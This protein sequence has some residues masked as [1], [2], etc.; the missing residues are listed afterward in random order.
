M[1]LSLLTLT[2]AALLAGCNPATEQKT[3][4]NP[5][6]A[7]AKADNAVANAAENNKAE[8]ETERLN[9]WFEAKYEEQLQ[10]S[11]LQLTFLGRKEKNDQ[12]D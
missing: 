9:K 6:P 12:I 3:E 8:T 2:I 11:P 1:R 5:T 4:Q 10:M 7:A